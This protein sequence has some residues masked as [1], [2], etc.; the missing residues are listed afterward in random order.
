MANSENDNLKFDKR[1]LSRNLAAGVI[2]QK[3]IEKYLAGLKD[4]KG[5]AE[6]IR[7]WDEEKSLPSERMGKILSQY[8]AQAEN[9]PPRGFA[10]AP[11]ESPPGESMSFDE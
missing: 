11:V 8:Q 10:P 7:I 5:N 3:D 1:C 2:N 9:T 4:E 6:E